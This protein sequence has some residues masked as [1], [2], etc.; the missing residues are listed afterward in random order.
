M[1]A[2]GDFAGIPVATGT[3]NFA[4][5]VTDSMNRTATGNF[6]VG[7]VAGSNFDGPAELPRVTVPSAMSDT[8]APGSVINVNA[9]G[10]LQAALNNAHCGD[11]ISLQAG[12]TF[13]G[14]FTVPAKSCDIDHWI[15]VRTSSRTAFCRQKGSALRRVMRVLRP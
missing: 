9:G 12:A 4:V 2:N 15:I 10:D 14:K 7:V 8:P 13:T 11:T 3:F 5:M 1:T 6:S